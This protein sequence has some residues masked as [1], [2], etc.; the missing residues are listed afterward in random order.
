ML[1]LV[2][3][4][5][6]VNSVYSTTTYFRAES[7]TAADIVEWTID[8]IVD[9]EFDFVLTSNG[10][11]ASL[12]INGVFQTG[13]TDVIFTGDTIVLENIGGAVSYWNFNGEMV[14]IKLYNYAFN[15]KEA[16]D[17]HNSFQKVTKKGNFTDFPVGSTIQK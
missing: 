4:S 8:N 16:I 10:K 7:S 9:E 5:Y 2:G 3:A 12:Y 13:S 1:Y 14:D 15:E 6:S 17:Y 11:V